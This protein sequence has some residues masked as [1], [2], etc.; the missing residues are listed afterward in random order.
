M[1][2]TTVYTLVNGDITH[3]NQQISEK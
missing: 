3:Q 2:H 1:Y